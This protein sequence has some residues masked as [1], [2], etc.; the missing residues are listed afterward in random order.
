MKYRIHFDPSTAKY[1]V[2]Y[3]I[4]NGNW[5]QCNDFRFNT[6]DDAEIYLS[7]CLSS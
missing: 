1:L 7:S 4:G 5:K 6:F 3:Q 2:C